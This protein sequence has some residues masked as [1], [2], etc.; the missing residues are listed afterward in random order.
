MSHS[1]T[2]AG[3]IRQGASRVGGL[4]KIG[5]PWREALSGLAAIAAADR[6]ET[7]AAVFALSTGVELPI[8]ITEVQRVDGDV[9]I[10][11]FRGSQAVPAA[12]GSVPA[13]A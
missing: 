11:R 9:L 13:P 2:R 7:G 8:E 3:E 12:R 6:L 5:R 1:E 4:A 10:V